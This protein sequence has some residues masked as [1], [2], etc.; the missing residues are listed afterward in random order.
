MSLSSRILRITPIAI[1]GM[2]LVAVIGIVGD[3]VQT[4]F[5]RRQ[6]SAQALALETAELEKLLLS[7]RG[8]ELGLILNRNPEMIDR[9]HDLQARVPD[10]FTALAAHLRALDPEADAAALDGIT[11]HWA[12]HTEQVNRLIDEMLRLGMDEDH[13]LEGTLRRAV[14]DAE[15]S[16]PAS[17]APELMVKILMMRR[18]EKDF[19]MRGDSKYVDRLRQRM[20]EVRAMPT[21][22]FGDAAAQA[23]VVSSLGA[24]EAAFL[25]F[26][27]LQME[28]VATRA[29]VSESF[30]EVRPDLDAL[31][32]I[33]MEEQDSATSTRDTLILV[34]WVTVAVLLLIAV[35][36]VTLI[37]RRLAHAVI[38]PLTETA[39]ALSAFAE[40]RTDTRLRGRKRDDEIGEIARAFERLQ[41]RIQA[42]SAT[43]EARIRDQAEE[44]R[45]RSAAEAA[46]TRA[47]KEAL[48]ATLASLG[49]ALDRLAHGDLSV[50]VGDRVSGEF[51]PLRT[52]FNDTA[53]RLAA[54]VR[55]IWS[56]THAIA[57]ATGHIATDAAD[58]TE[59]ATNQA[60]SLEE[61]AATIEEISATVRTNA[62][63]TGRADAAVG[64]VVRRARAGGA[65]VS[66][67]QTAMTR[68]EASS[69][70]IAEING[71]IGSIA[72]QTNLLALN[73][74]VEAAR[75]G[76]A[77]KGFAVV[78]SEV[79]TL[80]QRASEA[81]KDI[82]DLVQE[83]S[84][85]VSD[86][87]RLVRETGSALGEINESVS[88]LTVDISD[89]SAA[90]REQ[91]TA[92]TEIATN[93]SAM[94]AMTQRSAELAEQSATR[95]RELEHEAADLRELVGFFDVER[96]GALSNAA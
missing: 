40:G 71:V 17:A 44:E 35:A 64:E 75:A 3:F 39:A 63:S 46:R 67:A 12:G 74:A 23:T 14:H 73:A 88:S 29:A 11:A 25:A 57:D 42:E 76:E 22:A 61:T 68:I 55:R 43:R 96:K 54:L 4:R 84:Q 21:S 81:A 24:Y 45:E 6:T 87:A 79:R 52:A 65:V 28:A 38:G 50:R 94:D 53:D 15:E 20:E 27:A 32:A 51:A 78:A 47:E 91:A 86:G 36:L 5:D 10:T 16:V 8:M 41:Q 66:E 89:I 72:F 48:D 83:S 92:V 90:S 18:H 95:A 82:S 69:S 26:A 77:G 31:Q 1:G 19:M 34:R 9:L 56:A 13:G 60:A 30:R 49:T 58:L 93:V 70:R 7:G 33:A 2:L 37:I 85:L 62:E 59:R 80:A